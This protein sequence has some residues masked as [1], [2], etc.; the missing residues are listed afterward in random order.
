MSTVAWAAWVALVMATALTTTNPYVLAILLASVV[1]VAVAAPRTERAG[2]GLRVM[3]ALGLGL[4]VFSI[5]AAMLNTGF[6]ERVLFTLPRAS[7]PDWLGGLLLGGEVTAE[8]L[9]AGAVR[10]A[11]VLAVLLGFAVFSGAVSA[12]AILRL[13][14]A[15]LFHAGLVVTIGLALLPATIADIRHIREMQALRGRP[16]GVRGLPALVAPAVMGGLDRAMR[17]AEAMEARGYAAPPAVPART[18]LAGAVAAPLLVA[19]AWVWFYQ[20]DVRWIGAAAALAGAGALLFWGW[21][22]A[23]RQRVTRLTVE[24]EPLLPRLAARLSLAGA[25]ALVIAD[26][27]GWLPGGYNPFAGFPAPPFSALAIAPA[28]AALWPLPFLIAA[29]RPRVRSE[30]AVPPP[31]P[32]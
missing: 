31:L 18:R 24:R 7:A 25:V 16:T 20:P 19:A 9:V 22:C 32:S 6:G 11:V 8:T 3:L 12:H 23:R 4:F 30:P 21:D 10:G 29:P 27:G 15:A 26:L 14:P 1:L 13:A 2:L 17:F 5:G 28:V